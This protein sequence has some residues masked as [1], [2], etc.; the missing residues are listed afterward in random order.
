MNLLRIPV[1][2]IDG[3]PSRGIGNIDDGA[4]KDDKIVADVKARCKA[5]GVEVPGFITA[6]D[7]GP[8]EDTEWLQ[9]L[10]QTPTSTSG[11]ARCRG[12][13]SGRAAPGRSPRRSCPSS[14]ARRWAQRRSRRTTWTAWARA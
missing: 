7:Y 9:D 11:S 13:P 1:R 5:N 8:S 10:W 4:Y 14:S 12:G 6:E 2:A 3:H